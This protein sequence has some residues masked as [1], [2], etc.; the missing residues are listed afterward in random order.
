MFGEAEERERTAYDRV[1][2]TLLGTAGTVRSSGVT[3]P[4]HG[5]QD[6]GS[7]PEDVTLRR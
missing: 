3:A 5:R 4:R 6:G 1:V 2:G 7:A